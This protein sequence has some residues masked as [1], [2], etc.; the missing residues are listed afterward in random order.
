LR[1]TEH[2]ALLFGGTLQRPVYTSLQYTAQSGTSLVNLDYNGNQ[3]LRVPKISLSASP[4]VSL[5]KDRLRAEISVERYGT[6]YADAANQQKLP[7]YTV[8]SANARLQLSRT[9]TFYVNSYNL[10]NAI[11]LT[12]G[13]PN[14]S[15][16]LTSQAG[17][18][19]FV[20][21]PILGRSVKISL[22]YT[23]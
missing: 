4:A 22:L 7:P 5:F 6:R 3:L 8:V 16:I 13:S 10:T 11:G 17:A 20:A 9:L 1:L 19:V 21:R 14:S 12:E 15:E 2:F 18:P 23:F